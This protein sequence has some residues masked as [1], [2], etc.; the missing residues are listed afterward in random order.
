MVAWSRMLPSSLELAA[1]HCFREIMGIVIPSNSMGFEA[2][3]RG[4]CYPTSL[5]TTGL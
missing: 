3:V 2:A 5:A 4:L 1:R